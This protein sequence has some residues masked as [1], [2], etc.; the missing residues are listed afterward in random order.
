MGNHSCAQLSTKDEEYVSTE[1]DELEWLI[2]QLKHC[3][4]LQ[5]APLGAIRGWAW[6]IE[7]HARILREG[8]GRRIERDR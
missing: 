3:A 7:D 5:G 8:L 1:I 4:S 6:D 2:E